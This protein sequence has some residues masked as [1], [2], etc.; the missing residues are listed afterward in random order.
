MRL[1]VGAM[2]F[3]LAV[4]CG[5][6][7]SEAGFASGAE[8]SVADPD[9]SV[10]ADG[11]TTDTDG[12]TDDTAASADAD[13]GT[14]DTASSGDVDGGP[15]D[16]AASADADG[17]GDADADGTGDADAD[18]TGDADADGG[19]SLESLA[20]TGFTVSDCDG[21][22][23]SASMEASYDEAAGHVSVAHTSHE[24]NCCADF[25]LTATGSADG[26]LS[27]VYDEGEALC[28]CICMYNL[29]YNVVGLPSGEWSISIPDGL[30]GVVTVP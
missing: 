18:G 7:E 29:S 16:T 14:D 4:A 2:L 25:S 27:V 21:S 11:G 5:K 19:S 3:G 30:T 24:A 1:V 17:T 20:V 23:G 8:P 13:G 28:D 6:N 26:S 22:E 9:S 15:D 12:G 10:V